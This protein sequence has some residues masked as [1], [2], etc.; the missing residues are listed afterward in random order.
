MSSAKK[1][2]LIAISTLLVVM[3]VLPLLF[4]AFVP[5]EAAMAFCFILFFAVDP[6]AI[7]ALSIMAGTEIGDLW[8]IPLASAVSFPVFFSVAIWEPV[9]D[10]FVYS[11]VYL[12]AGVLAMLGTHFGIKYIKKKKHT[13]SKGDRT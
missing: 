13:A 4:V 6:L 3:L 5:G 7:L 2:I 12:P 1:K 8:W 11:A 10:L 9:V